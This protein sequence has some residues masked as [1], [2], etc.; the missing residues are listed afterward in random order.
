MNII[1]F[2]LAFLFIGFPLSALIVILIIIFL[3]HD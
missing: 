1:E 3:P 2:A